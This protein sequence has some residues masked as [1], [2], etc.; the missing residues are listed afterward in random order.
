MGAGCL[1]AAKIILPILFSFKFC[2]AVAF[3]VATFVVGKD[4]FEM[5]RKREQM[6][7]NPNFPALDSRNYL[8]A[9]LPNEAAID[10]LTEK[11][12][13]SPLWKAILLRA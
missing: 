11:T 2:L 1:L 7:A 10:E 8:L 5:A 6:H 12:L 13:A 9:K 4:A 3:A